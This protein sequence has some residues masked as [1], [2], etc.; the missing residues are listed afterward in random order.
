MKFLNSS[1]R[2]GDIERLLK[3]RRGFFLRILLRAVP[4]VGFELNALDSIVGSGE[5]EFDDAPAFFVGLRK[6]KPRV[7][8]ERAFVRIDRSGFNR[9]KPVELLVLLRPFMLLKLRGPLAYCGARC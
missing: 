1:R 2:V 3:G 4:F 9:P 8:R 6:G 7:L 5:R